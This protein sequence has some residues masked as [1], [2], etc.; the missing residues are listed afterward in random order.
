MKNFALRQ[1][2]IETSDFQMV[3]RDIENGTRLRITEC[4]G[5]KVHNSQCKTFVQNEA[6]F[7]T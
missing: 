4:I 5:I 6:K 3:T 1:I 2:K 7:D